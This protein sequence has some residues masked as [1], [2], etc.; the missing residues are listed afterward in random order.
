VQ[1]TEG[2]DSSVL[3][4]LAFAFRYD[5]SWDAGKR[6]WIDA[7]G[8]RGFCIVCFFVHRDIGYNTFFSLSRAWYSAS[9]VLWKE[10]FYSTIH[11]LF[12][13]KDSAHY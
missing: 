3:S 11:H 9:L 2:F 6:R 10:G 1:C 12:G 8:V 4:I 5:Y 7:K 13:L